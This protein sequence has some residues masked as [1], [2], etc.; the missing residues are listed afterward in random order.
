[1]TP[2]RKGLAGRLRWSYKVEQDDGQDIQLETVRFPSR[3]WLGYVAMLVT[4][5]WMSRR[6]P[7]RLPDGTIVRR[8]PGGQVEYLE[9]EHDGFR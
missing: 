7:V 2:A 9:P 8:R 4:S 1:M 5:R 6:G 3:G